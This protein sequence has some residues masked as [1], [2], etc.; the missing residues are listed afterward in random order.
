M[1]AA[2]FDGGIVSDEDVVQYETEGR[3]RRFDLL[4][5]SLDS[6]IDDSNAGSGPIRSLA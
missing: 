1:R 4:G 6:A 3:I 2:C 5:V